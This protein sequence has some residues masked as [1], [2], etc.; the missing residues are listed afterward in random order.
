MFSIWKSTIVSAVIIKLHWEIKTA[1]HNCFDE[2]QLYLFLCVYSN[3]QFSALD[4]QTII[5]YKKRE[6]IEKNI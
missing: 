4:I 6:K 3:I 1:I 5:F 2:Y